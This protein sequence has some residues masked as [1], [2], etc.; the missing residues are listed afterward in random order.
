MGAETLIGTA[1]AVLAS[2]V[3]E[4]SAAEAE[5]IF[6]ATYG[7]EG[8]AELLAGERDRNFLMREP[9]GGG[10][11]LKITN[12]V[13]EPAVTEFQTA[14]LCH[15]ALSDPDFPVPR[16]M[17]AA[18]GALI[19]WGV[20]EG[21][22]PRAVRLF[23]WL[24]GALLGGRVLAP[25]GL[26]DLGRTLARLALALRGFS[27]PAERH[28]LL[29]DM[30]HAVALRPLLTMIPDETARGWV[31]RLIDRFEA[32]VLPVLAALP[33]GV[34]HNDLTGSNLLMRVDDGQRVAGVL[35][36][37]D[38]VRAPLVQ[39]LGVT[40]SYHLDRADGADLF[41]P[42]APLLAGYQ[43]LRPLTEPEALVLFDL[44]ATRLALRGLIP[45]WRAALYPENRDYLLRNAGR[46]WQVMGRVAEMDPSW[47]QAQLFALWDRARDEVTA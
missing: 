29:W 26:R 39:E 32:R 46:A 2:P 43:A 31:A 20:E 11:M 5:A 10:F 18:D 28:P 12:P 22:R 17:P 27:H 37:G 7:R 45:A 15:V 41:A 23:T 1:A 36:F 14:A 44:I 38:M 25:E 4:V 40:A 30:Q 16:V 6:R 21:G 33:A 13:E 42:L 3:P 35:D 19:A 34:I 8:V 9:G 47:G 24:D